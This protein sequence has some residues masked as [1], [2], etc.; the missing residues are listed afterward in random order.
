MN[1]SVK[2]STDCLWGRPQNHQR[3]DRQSARPDIHVRRPF[4][5]GRPKPIRLLEREQWPV[6][7]SSSL[8]GTDT[9]TAQVAPTRSARSRTARRNDSIRL[10]PGVGDERVP[11][12]FGTAPT[13]VF[14]IQR[15]N[16]S[17][18]P[19]TL[20][21]PC[22]PRPQR[23]RLLSRFN[24]GPASHQKELRRRDLALRHPSSRRHPRVA[25][26]ADGTRSPFGE[27]RSLP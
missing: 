25:V 21:L 16:Y 13:A 5:N 9:N 15:M 26:D 10:G 18:F 23:H 12:I 6:P 8:G 24:P 4:G 11:P 19:R 7:L 20:L 14:Q 22:S 17:W 1:Q 27:L 3:V 2:R